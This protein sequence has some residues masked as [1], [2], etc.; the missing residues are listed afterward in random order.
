MATVGTWT[1]ENL[2]RVNPSI[3]LDYRSYPGWH[4]AFSDSDY[5]VSLE[6][7]VS[8]A[9]QKRGFYN[10]KVAVNLIIRTITPYVFSIQSFQLTATRSIV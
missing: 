3:R 4:D 7:A 10:Y 8:G 1:N 9:R 5:Y 6:Y 2:A